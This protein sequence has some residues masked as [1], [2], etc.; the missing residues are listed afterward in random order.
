MHP[1]ICRM[2]NTHLPPYP[3]QDSSKP[4]R[5]KHI[6]LNNFQEKIILLCFKTYLHSNPRRKFNRMVRKLSTDLQ[7]IEEIFPGWDTLTP[8]ERRF[9][10]NNTVTQQY[11]KNEIIQYEGDTPTHM[12]VLA[13]G[14]AK[15]YKEGVGSQVQIIRMLKVGNPFSYRGIIANGTYNT[16]VAA[17]EPSVVY[18]VK[19]DVF[20]SVLRHN[21]EFCYRFLEELACDLADSDTRS[22]NLSQKHIRGRLA[23]TLL[24]LKKNYGL[25]EDGVTINIYLSREDLANMSNMTTSNAIRTLSSFVSEHV[26]AMDG[27]RLKII[28]EDKL[29]KISR[30]G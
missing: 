28:D 7:P 19:G 13:A 3:R 15:V 20:T 10:K 8:D 26:L 21:N 12:M 22:I 6:F 11:K 4:H 27:R 30:L 9:I 23:E 18:Q 17:L 2:T 16:T 5:A 29:K 25:E 24:L 1:R 14:K